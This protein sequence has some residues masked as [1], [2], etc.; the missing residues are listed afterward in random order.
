[1]SRPCPGAERTADPDGQ[2]HG[3]PADGSLHVPGA[4][5]AC[6]VKGEGDVVLHGHGLTSSRAADAARGLVDY[7]PVASRSRLIAYDARGHGRSTGPLRDE[8]YRWP[9]LARDM[10]A[11]ADH[12]SPDRPIGRSAS[13]ERPWE[14]RPRCTR[15]FWR[16]TAS[17]ALSAPRLPPPGKGGPRK[18]G[19]TA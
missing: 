2:K 5:L 10:L 14:P 1:M 6:T 19:S 17:P 7:R 4:D 18:P 16:R 15:C 11:M 9:N 13:S 12:F 3:S 8:D